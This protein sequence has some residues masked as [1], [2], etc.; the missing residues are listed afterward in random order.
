[1]LYLLQHHTLARGNELRSLNLCDMYVGDIPVEM[2]PD[3]SPCLTFLLTESKTND[4]GEKEVISCVRNKEV[5]VCPVGAISMLFY[6]KYHGGRK[7]QRSKE[8]NF[9]TKQSW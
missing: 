8:P 6:V 1:M 5:L 9:K 4:S 3:S 2:R 7:Q